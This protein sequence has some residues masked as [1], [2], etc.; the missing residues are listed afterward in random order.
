METIAKCLIRMGKNFLKKF[1]RCVDELTERL[2]SA[3]SESLI[4][5]LRQRFSLVLKPIWKLSQNETFSFDCRAAN[6]S[7]LGDLTIL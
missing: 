6:R 5:T 4:L 2:G 7:E 1:L 3:F